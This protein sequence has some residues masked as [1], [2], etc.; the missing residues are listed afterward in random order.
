MLWLVERGE[1][2]VLLVRHAFWRIFLLS[3]RNDNAEFRF[4]TM[5]SAAVKLSFSTFSWNPSVPRQRNSLLRL[6]RTTW[7]TWSNSKTIN[8]TQSSILMWRFRCS[9]RHSFFKNSQ[10]CS[11]RKVDNNGYWKIIWE[12]NSSYSR[13]FSIF[14]TDS[15]LME[16]AQIVRINR[17]KTKSN[18]F[19]RILQEKLALMIKD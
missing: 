7:R 18:A 17:D 13:H 2:I 15:P 16:S 6:F 12:C 10:L 14:F 1:I 4:L 11:S 19:V 9:N 5:Q 3:P 8:L